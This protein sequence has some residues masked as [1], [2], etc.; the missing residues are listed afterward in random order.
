MFIKFMLILGAQ[1]TVKIIDV[2][3]WRSPPVQGGLEIPVLVSV[4]MDCIDSNNLLM[5]NLKILYILRTIHSDDEDVDS[6]IT[7]DS[8]EDED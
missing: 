1:V 8:G 7:D 2:Y 5:E 4:A 6:I 3:Y